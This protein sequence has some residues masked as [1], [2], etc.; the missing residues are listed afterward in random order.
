M[1][2]Y[3]RNPSYQRR[4]QP[5]SCPVDYP[6]STVPVKDCPPP[7]YQPTRHNPG[8]MK[9]LQ[10]YYTAQTANGEPL[11]GHGKGWDEYARTGQYTR[12]WKWW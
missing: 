7:G 5:Y 3:V 1:D 4:C 12:W 8:G 9:F 11:Q 10:Y 2:T 6:T